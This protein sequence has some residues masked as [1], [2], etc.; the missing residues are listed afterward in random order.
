MKK[1]I[2]T[3][4]VFVQQDFQIYFIFHYKIQK[5]DYSSSSNFLKY[6]AT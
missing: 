3:S 6:L 5:V 4:T 1:K 2:F